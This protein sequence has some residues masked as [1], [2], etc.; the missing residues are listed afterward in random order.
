MMGTTKKYKIQAFLRPYD[1]APGKM[2]R[3]LLG[4]GRE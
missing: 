1:W 3:N 4:E 2:S